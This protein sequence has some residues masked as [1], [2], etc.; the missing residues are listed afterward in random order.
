MP[1]E[2]RQVM[3]VFAFGSAKL[4]NRND[5]QDA[6]NYVNNRDIVNIA[7]IATCNDLQQANLIYT[8]YQSESFFSFFL[9][10]FMDSEGYQNVL[11]DECINILNNN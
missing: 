5:F 4:F 6:K 7:A 8:G 11:K 3:E 9:D 2:V 1:K 10:H